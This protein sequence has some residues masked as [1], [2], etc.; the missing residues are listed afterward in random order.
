MTSVL[1]SA[2]VLFVALVFTWIMP[3]LT[4]PTLPF[5]VRVPA[6]R[7]ADPHVGRVRRGYRYT[8]VGAFIVCAGAMV[9]LRESASVVWLTQGL[10]LLGV[11]IYAAA[12][13]IAHRRL[14]GVKAREN[15]YAGQ[16]EALVA[17]VDAQSG[18]VAYPWV[19][20]LPALLALGA[21]IVIGAL[22]YPKLPATIPTHFDIN[23]KP[24]GFSAKG[25]AA[26]LLPGMEAAL[27]ILF[28]GLTWLVQRSRYDIDPADPQ[29]SSAQQR[30]FRVRWGRALLLFAALTNITLLL[31]A[32]LMWQILPANRPGTFAIL[33][34]PEAVILLGAFGL[35]IVTGQGGARL[36]V[37]RSGGTTGL[38][39]R[40]DDRYWKGG[41][42]YYNPDDP[43]FLVEKRFG[44]GW[45][46]NFASKG[47]WA[48]MGAIVLVIVA[49]TLLPALLR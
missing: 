16:R 13:Y 15:W 37:A 17:N 20:L 29:A 18:R 12:Y 19:W 6:E 38:V 4:Q 10:A 22:R 11:V 7:A 1:L 26:F 27:T 8:L 23:G 5:G 43:A 39:H 33:L 3:S 34:A 25:P 41:L 9:A 24:N 21:T 42:F 48:F 32:L 44:V 49:S 14:Q 30:G 46:V 31:G 47:A 36:R 40:D 35:A 2:S 28:A 45:T